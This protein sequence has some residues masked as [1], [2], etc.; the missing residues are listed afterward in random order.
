MGDAGRGAPVPCLKSP[1]FSR[2]NGGAGVVVGLP[3]FGRRGKGD[4]G[5]PRKDLNRKGCKEHGEEMGEKGKGLPVAAVGVACRERVAS[6]EE[7]AL[8]ER[9]ASRLP[10]SE[11]LGGGLTS[12]IQV[13]WGSSLC[14]DHPIAVISLTPVFNLMRVLHC[15]DPPIIRNLLV[16]PA[17]SEEGTP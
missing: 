16:N 4:R 8:R 9:T 13:V 11:G 6:R 14:G 10:S 7:V 2:I 15:G 1:V 5:E 12:M 17:P 3:G